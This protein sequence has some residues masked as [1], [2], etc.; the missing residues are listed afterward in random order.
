MTD[1]R[2]RPQYVIT[3]MHAV[4]LTNAPMLRATDPN[5]SLTLVALLT[6]TVNPNFL[7]LLHKQ[8]AFFCNAFGGVA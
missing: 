3:G 5:L 4:L 2:K 1:H 6:L 8:L 7:L